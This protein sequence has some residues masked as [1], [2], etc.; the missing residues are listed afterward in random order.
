MYNKT[1]RY[2][3]YN[4]MQVISC[5]YEAMIGQSRIF[6]SSKWFIKICDLINDMHGVQ[7]LNY[8]KDDKGNY[9]LYG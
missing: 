7:H 5:W 6:D 9:I 2:K 4:L 8:V 1:L 3:F